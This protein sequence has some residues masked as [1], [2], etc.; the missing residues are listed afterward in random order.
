VQPITIT[1]LFGTEVVGVETGLQAVDIK[2]DHIGTVVAVIIINTEEFMY[3]KR[4]T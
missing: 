1:I 3:V 2:T 4:N